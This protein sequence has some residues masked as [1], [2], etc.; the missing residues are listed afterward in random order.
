MIKRNVKRSISH[1]WSNWGLIFAVIVVLQ[2]QN[3][4]YGGKKG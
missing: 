1:L 3:K 2:A 4:Q